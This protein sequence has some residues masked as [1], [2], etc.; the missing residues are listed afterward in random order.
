[1]KQLLIDE[2]TEPLLSSYAATDRENA[3]LQM[4]LS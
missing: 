1:M 4:T 3:L 2:L